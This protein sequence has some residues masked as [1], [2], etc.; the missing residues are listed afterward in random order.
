MTRIDLDNFAVDA[1]DFAPEMSWSATAE[2]GVEVELDPVSHVLLIRRVE[3]SLDQPAP[4]TSK[5]ILR[6]RR[7]RAPVYTSRRRYEV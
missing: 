5:V 7:M 3:T 6:T 1:E 2:P 4:A